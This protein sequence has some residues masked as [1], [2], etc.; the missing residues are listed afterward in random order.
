VLHY[1]GTGWEPM[2]GA[3]TVAFTSI[4][5]RSG[6]AVHAL[7]GGRG[8]LDH[9]GLRWTL[10][11][12]LDDA[13]LEGLWVSPAGDLFGV[14]AGATA[15]RF[16]GA[17][18][19][20]VVEGLPGIDL[21]AAWG[22]ATDRLWAVGRTI[23]GGSSAAV[24]RYD[25]ARWSVPATE[26]PLPAADLRA[27][28]GST[29]GETWA[30]GTGGTIVRCPPDAPCAVVEAGVTGALR[31]VWSSETGQ[32]YA[33]GDGGAIL[34]YDGETWSSMTSPTA[35]TLRAVWGASAADVFAAGDGATLLRYDGDDWVP[36]DLGGLTTRNLTGIWG[37]AT[38]NVFV[39]ADDAGTI[40]HR[41]GPAW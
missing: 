6:H 22:A 32:A 1:D 27:V 10:S 20:P 25:G 19:E 33:V 28:A 4:V 5:G 40:L 24:V 36:I 17:T 37:S 31:G 13:V 23:G 26:R 35:R 2:E 21:R 12:W 7:G 14:G 11:S 15:V 38:N 18:W 3:A 41:C 9:D 16:D 8:V 29:A 30:V 34:R 39:V